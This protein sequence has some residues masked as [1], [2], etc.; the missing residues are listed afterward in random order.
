M[1]YAQERLSATPPC[2][3]SKLCWT[4]M[5]FYNV[6]C[7]GVIHR[8]L[9]RACN[10]RRDL[11]SSEVLLALRDVD[12][13]EGHFSRGGPVFRETFQILWMTFVKLSAWSLQIQKEMRSGPIAVFFRNNFKANNSRP[14]WG[15][16]FWKT[17][18]AIRTCVCHLEI[19][20]SWGKEGNTRFA[21]EGH[22]RFVSVAF[23]FHC[24]CW[25]ARY[26]SELFSF[27]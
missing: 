2:R 9:E 11:N 19:Q 21:N 15:R 27:S 7:M 18:Y 13:R 20:R 24:G 22:M 16:G 26:V 6:S 8:F 4:Q 17:R 3:I 5:L 1:L 12:L 25:K 14:T 10:C 23:G